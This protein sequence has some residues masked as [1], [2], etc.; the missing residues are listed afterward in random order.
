MHFTT[1]PIFQSP[2]F[3]FWANSFLITWATLSFN[4]VRISFARPPWHYHR[5]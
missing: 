3:P 1:A 4:I 2:P 5:R